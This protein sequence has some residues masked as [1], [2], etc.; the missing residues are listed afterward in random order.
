MSRP[1]TGINSKMEQLVNLPELTHPGESWPK[2]GPF[3]RIWDSGEGGLAFFFLL[4]EA[5]KIEDRRQVCLAGGA[6]WGGQDVVLSPPRAQ[7]INDELWKATRE[8]RETDF[9]FF[10]HASID[11][12]MLIGSTKQS[13]WIDTSEED[14]HYFKATKKDLTER[15]LKLFKMLTEIYGEEP[16]IITLLDT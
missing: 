5:T 9:S 2:A 4:E 1:R 7:R 12:A 8:S 11:L 14:G 16:M 3:P 15:G 6:S 13:I 10:A